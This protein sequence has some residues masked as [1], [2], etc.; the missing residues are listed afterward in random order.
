M[1]EKNLW[2]KNGIIYQIYPRSFSDSNNDGIG[3]LPGIISRLDYLSDLGVDAIWLSPVYPSPQV[4]FGYDV[5]NYVDINPSFGNLKDFDQLVRQAHKRNIRVIMDLVFNHTSDD[6][7][8]FVQSRQ[9]R[10]NPYHDWYL[11]R[12]PNPQGGPPNN[13]Y[14]IFGGKA[15]KYDETIGQ[16]YLHTFDERQ[17]DLNWRNPQVQKAI[18]DVMKFW[19]KHGTDG[20]RLDVFNAYFKHPELRD[21]PPSF[22]LRGYERQQH[23]HDMDQPEMIPLLQEFRRLLNDYPDR[24][25]V[26]E[27]FLATP[28]KASFYCGEDRLHAAFNFSLLEKRWNPKQFFSAINEWEKVSIDWIWPTNVLNNHDTPRSVT[29]WHD[30]PLDQRAKIAATLLLTLRG[31]PFLYYGEEIG[32]RNVRL[33]R[34]EVMDPPGKRY[35]PLYK[36]RDGCRSP[37]QWDTTLFSGFSE[38]HPWLKIHPDYPQRNVA[39][40]L[41]DEY[42]LLNFYRRLI[43]LR[44][45]NIVLRQGDFS[46]VKHNNPNCLVYRRS[47]GNNSILVALNFRNKAQ[48]PELSNNEVVLWTEIFSTH[49]LQKEPKMLNSIH[50]EPYQVTLFELTR[51]N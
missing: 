28:S 27:T 8:W 44:R 24:Y 12:N 42:S 49:S 43:R 16:Y 34:S 2:W 35:N 50:L 15:W 18:L 30:D 7:P 4:D 33:K 1:E 51:G 13:W 10:D 36:G 14:S 11:W 31:T 26:G 32:M 9:S 3:D 20:F 21:N 5:S 39:V 22:G 17:P 19:L 48:T 46:F 47:Y 23:I 38:I 45:Q 37:M 29:R 40:Q 6:H 41:Q 25:M